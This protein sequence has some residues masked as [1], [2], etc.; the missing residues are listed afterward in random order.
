VDVALDPAVIE[1]ALEEAR[2]VQVC[3]DQWPSLQGVIIAASVAL[4][5]SLEF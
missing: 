1:A 4:T 5:Q 2:V 3:F